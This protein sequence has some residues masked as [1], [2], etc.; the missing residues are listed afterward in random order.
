MAGPVR[1]T[2]AHARYA[3]I[4]MVSIAALVGGL[5]LAAAFGFALVRSLGR[6]LGGEPGQ[7]AD[8]ARSVAAG[9][10]SVRIDLRTG[11]TTSLMARL[12]EMQDSLA[13]VVCSVRRNSESVALASAEISQGNNDLS[14]RTEQQAAALEETAA[15]PHSRADRLVTLL[16]A[17]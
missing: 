1:Y 8:L 9:D 10:L 12:R 6:Q 2:A 14:Q 11:D 3:T 5:L 17:P 4:R 15:S 7:A 16:I 13:K